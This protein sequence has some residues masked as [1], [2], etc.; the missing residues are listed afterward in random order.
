MY[1]TAAEVQ[2]QIEETSVGGQTLQQ[3][4]AEEQHLH[5][6]QVSSTGGPERFS[7]IRTVSLSRLYKATR[8]LQ[9]TRSASVFRAGGE[10]GQ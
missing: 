1:L 6:L 5:E 7:R 2:L 3:Q 8:G 10:I 9:T 4:P